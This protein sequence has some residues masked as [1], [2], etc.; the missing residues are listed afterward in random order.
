MSLNNVNL[1]NFLLTQNANYNV[2]EDQTDYSGLPIPLVREDIAVVVVTQIAEEVT[3]NLFTRDEWPLSYLNIFDTDYHI[4][5]FALQR[6]NPLETVDIDVLRWYDYTV[7]KSLQNGNNTTPMEGSHWTE[8]TSDTIEDFQ[9]VDSEVFLETDMYY[10]PVQNTTLG[11]FSLRKIGDHRYSIIYNGLD[12][13]ITEHALYDYKNVLIGAWKSAEPYTEIQIVTPKDGVYY[14]QIELSDGTTQYIEIYDFTD[15]EEC[16]LHLVKNVLCEC[17]DCNDCPDA[18]YKRLLT[19]VNL[20]VLI[21]DIVYADRM[22][23]VGLLSNDVLRTDWL[24]SLGML[25]SKLAIMTE[26][27]ICE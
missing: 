18:S 3:Y 16:F 26:Q 7:W 17:I 2:M 20:Y 12:Y 24:T 5:A 22:V 8:V 23:N 21:R 19:F 1:F 27:C 6:F 13:E 25:I 14:V 11:Q 9:S 4:W 15:A 10:R